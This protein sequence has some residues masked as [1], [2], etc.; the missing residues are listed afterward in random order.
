MT[1]YSNDGYLGA[2]LNQYKVTGEEFMQRYKYEQK[3]KGEF[4]LYYQDKNNVL[5]AN[6]NE[7]ILKKENNDTSQLF[8]M[9]EDYE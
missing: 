8:K 6:G 7:L 2:D 4:I 1:L 9:I 3:N 5:T